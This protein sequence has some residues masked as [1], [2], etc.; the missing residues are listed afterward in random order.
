[1]NP[2]GKTEKAM[3]EKEISLESSFEHHA[4]IQSMVSETFQEAGDSQADQVH[5]PNGRLNSALL[6]RNAK[7]LLAAGDVKLAKNI[8]RALVESGETLG[9]A[10]SGL[11]GCYELEGKFDLAIKAYREAIIFEPTFGCLFALAEL[12]IKK[13]EYQNA[14]GTLL[15]ALN[16]PRLQS[17]QIFD[18]HKGLGSCYMQLGQPNNAEAHYRKAYEIN[19]GS[20][21]L[22]VNIG[23]LAM[24]KGDLATALLHF[25]EAAR[26]NPRNSSA[27]TGTGLAQMGLGNREAAHDAFAA[28]LSIDIHDVTSIYHLVKCAYELKK[29][30]VVAAL[31]EK[32]IKH[33][34]VNANILYSYAGIQYHRGMLPKALEECEKLLTLKADHEGAKKL[35]ELILGKLQR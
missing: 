4:A 32:Y 24:K 27:Q 7:I 16:L 23:S 21:S 18:L 29:F 8:F 2:E 31:L 12:Y 11:G 34:A 22:H 15:R 5:Q 28:A 17:A 20:D 10:Y 30:D 14:V 19:P 6:L 26:I 25:K 3:R 9:I 13:E 1:M 35:R 33:N